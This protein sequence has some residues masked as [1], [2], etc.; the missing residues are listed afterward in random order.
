[1]S[2]T[3]GDWLKT[4]RYPERWG[5][6]RLMHPLAGQPCDEIQMMNDRAFDGP[7]RLQ[8]LRSFYYNHRDFTNAEAVDREGRP[9]QPGDLVTITYRVTSVHNEGGEVPVV[10]L[11]IVGKDGTEHHAIGC[12]AD[13]VCKVG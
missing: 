6:D 8:Q 1:M 7:Q 4:Q 12:P 11:N 2:E 13:H 3:F 9:L 10:K 5:Q